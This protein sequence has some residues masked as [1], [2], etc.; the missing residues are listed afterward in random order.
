LKAVKKKV[1]KREDEVSNKSD[2]VVEKPI[3]IDRVMLDSKGSVRQQTRRL[4]L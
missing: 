4:N 2:E 3:D 1:K